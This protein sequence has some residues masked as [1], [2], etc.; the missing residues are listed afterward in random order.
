LIAKA[1]ALAVKAGRMGYLS[2]LPSEQEKASSSS[3][4]DWVLKL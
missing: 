2:G 3:P 1:F 4:L